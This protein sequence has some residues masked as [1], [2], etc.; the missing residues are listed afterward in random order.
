MCSWEA[1]ASL[2]LALRW[3]LAD[4]TAEVTADQQLAPERSVVAVVAERQISVLAA[5]LWRI[6]YVLRLVAVV[7]EHKLAAMAAEL[8][9]AQELLAEPRMAVQ[10]VRRQQAVQPVR[11]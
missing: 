9:E 10:A 8:Q 3:A 11:E 2:T 6:E 7:Q 4:S 1:L 5:L